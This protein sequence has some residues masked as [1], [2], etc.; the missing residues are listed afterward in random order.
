MIFQRFRAR[1]VQLGF[2]SYDNDNANLLQLLAGHPHVSYAGCVWEVEEFHTQSFVPRIAYTYVSLREVRPA[3][4]VR[5]T[6]APPL[7]PARTMKPL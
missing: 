3:E 5:V 2:E 1:R 4:L 7:P 6:E